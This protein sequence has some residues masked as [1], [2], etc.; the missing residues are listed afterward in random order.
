MIIFH[1]KRERLGW[2]WQQYHLGVEV[3]FNE[4]AYMN[5]QLFLH[6]IN[7]YLIPDLGEWL[8]LFTLDLMG[9]HKIPAVL[10]KLDLHNITPSLIPSGCTSLI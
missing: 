10:E 6:Y 7:T 3:G 8:T 5:D 1:G 9:S 4:K 2:E